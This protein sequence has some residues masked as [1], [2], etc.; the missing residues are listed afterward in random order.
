MD[1][2]VTSTIPHPFVYPFFD[3]F[4]STNTLSTA[5]SLLTTYVL[6]RTQPNIIDLCQANTNRQPYVPRKWCSRPDIASNPPFFCHQ[7]PSANLAHRSFVETPNPTPVPVCQQVDSSLSRRITFFAPE[8]QKTRCF[9]GLAKRQ[10]RRGRN[11]ILAL[12]N[13]ATRI[14]AATILRCIIC[15]GPLFCLPGRECP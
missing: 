13:V 14:S 11:Y 9:R 4:L 15:F 12:R 1:D 5:T 8:P 2:Y 3:R 6:T 7:N 10:E